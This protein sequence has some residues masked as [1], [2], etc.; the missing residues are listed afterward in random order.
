M[1]NGVCTPPDDETAWTEAITS[2]VELYHSN[3]P[4]TRKPDLALIEHAHNY[5]NAVFCQK[6][7]ESYS[8]VVT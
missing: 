7:A 6:L 4:H 8:S 5:D 2:I 3:R 1:P